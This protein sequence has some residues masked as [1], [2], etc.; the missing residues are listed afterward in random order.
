MI[1]SQLT[2]TS[3]WKHSSDTCFDIND[4]VDVAGVH[5][6]ECCEIDG[7]VVSEHDGV[8]VLLEDGVALDLEHVEIYARLGRRPLVATLLTSGRD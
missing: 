8:E 7:D 6:A 2:L 5:L 3:F 4:G 1:A